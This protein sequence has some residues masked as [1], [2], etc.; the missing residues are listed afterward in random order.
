VEVKATLA[1][2]VIRFYF[3]SKR[4]TKG[5]IR[6]MVTAMLKVGRGE[7]RL[8][9]FRERVEEAGFERLP[10]PLAPPEPLI[11]L[12][13]EYTFPF[14]VNSQA[15]KRLME[16]LQRQVCRLETLKACLKFLGEISV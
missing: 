8:E 12:E 15:V 2:E 7:L 16:K 11:L 5:L 9:E 6:K 10:L 1:G 4:F 3:T 13:V 14:Q